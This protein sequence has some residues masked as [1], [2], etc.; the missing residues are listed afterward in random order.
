MCRLH[1]RQCC[2]RHQR[3][4]SA[5][6]VTPVG[7]AGVITPFFVGLWGFALLPVGGALLY[8]AWTTA[9]V[10]FQN[11]DYEDLPHSR[12]VM[13]AAVIGLGTLIIAA[14]KAYLYLLKW[15]LD[16]IRFFTRRAG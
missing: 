13:V 15:T 2:P 3:T 14:A 1:V 16:L 12:Q 6:A 5:I 11:A 4:A 9:N 8:S 10:A 7:I